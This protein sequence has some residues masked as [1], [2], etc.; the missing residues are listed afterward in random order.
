MIYLIAIPVLM[1]CSFAW[2]AWGFV[3]AKIIDGDE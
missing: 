2:M 3:N 1:L